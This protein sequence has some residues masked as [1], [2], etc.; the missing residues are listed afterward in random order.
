MIDGFLW[1]FGIFF[2][3]VASVFAGK[4]VEETHYSDRHTLY[5]IARIYLTVLAVVVVLLILIGVSVLVNYSIQTG[6]PLSPSTGNGG[7]RP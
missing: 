3:V 1:V 7:T 4:Y 6:S 5:W 2:V